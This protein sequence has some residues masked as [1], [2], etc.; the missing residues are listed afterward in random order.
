[1]TGDLENSDFRLF[2]GTTTKALLDIRREGLV[3]QVSKDQANRGNHKVARR[4]GLPHERL[5]HC[6]RCCRSRMRHP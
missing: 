6:G 2:H 1:M 4:G 5:P 3:P